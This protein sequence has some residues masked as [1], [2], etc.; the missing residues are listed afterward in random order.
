MEPGVSQVD[1]A[2]DLP[3]P[4]TA[5]WYLITGCND[6]GEG[7]AGAGTVTPRIINST[8]DCP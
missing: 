7:S 8:G 5:Y 3:A 2:T 6:V 4:G 1:L